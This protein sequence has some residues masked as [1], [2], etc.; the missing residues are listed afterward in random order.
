MKQFEDINNWV[1]K[2]I[3]IVCVNDT[4]G[5]YTTQRHFKSGEVLNIKSYIW[6]KNVYPEYEFCLTIDG[7]SIGYYQQKDFKIL[8]DYRNDRLEEIL[9]D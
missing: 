7:Y 9:K 1:D 2:E 5:R 4:C 6:K 3:K 8:A